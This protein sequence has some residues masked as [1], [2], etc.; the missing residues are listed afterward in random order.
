[1]ASALALE[2]N[3]QLES[4]KKWECRLMFPSMVEGEPDINL[5]DFMHI[6]FPHLWSSCVQPGLIPSNTAY[7]LSTKLYCDGEASY[8]KLHSNLR[9]AA[10][11]SGFELLT[12]SSK[13]WQGSANL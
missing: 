7:G 5:C 8:K 2:L 1:M 10:K 11:D 3:D 12:S 9:A 6:L 13:C 4:V